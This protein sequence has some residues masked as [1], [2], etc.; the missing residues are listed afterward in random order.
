MFYE[1]NV[2]TGS[3]LVLALSGCA[4]VPQYKDASG[5]NTAKLRLTMEEPIIS[6][7]YLGTVELE[8]CKQ[9]SGFQW[10]SG[11]ND[12]YRTK[13][14]DMLGS[15]PNGDGT[16]EY[17]IHAGQGIAAVPIQHIAKLNA[18]EIL[19]STGWAI[20]PHIANKQPGLCPSPGFVP[21]AGGQYEVSYKVLPGKCETKIYELLRDDSGIKKVD[22]TD[23]L[24]IYV[25]PTDQKGQY[26][27]T[28]S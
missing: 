1:K 23:K 24:G 4:G 11:G 5:P 8:T 27:C 10:V 2:F 25:S 19:L 3:L 17:V 26:T 15:I 28:E 18:A 14:V 7:L 12:S 9:K 13:R 20:K 16:I 21:E 6:Y 22:V